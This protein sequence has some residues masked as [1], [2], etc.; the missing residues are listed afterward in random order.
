MK[1]SVFF[2]RKSIAFP[3]LFEGIFKVMSKDI[4]IAFF[5]HEVAME[6]A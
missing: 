2:H 4:F 6:R 3:T 5:N 1:I